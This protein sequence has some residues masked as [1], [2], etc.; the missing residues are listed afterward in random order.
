MTLNDTLRDNSLSMHNC[1]WNITTYI[2]TKPDISIN[3]YYNSANIFGVQV[4]DTKFKDTKAINVFEYTNYT[5]RCTYIEQIIDIINTIG[6]YI[7]LTISVDNSVF[8]KE[9]IIKTWNK[10]KSLHINIVN[11]TLLPYYKKLSELMMFYDFI[12]DTSTLN[13][14]INNYTWIKEMEES[15][16]TICT[17][18]PP[19]EIDDIRDCLKPLNPYG[20]TIEMDLTEIDNVYPHANTED[21]IA[22]NIRNQKHITLELFVNINTGMVTMTMGKY[23]PIIWDI[24]TMDITDNYKKILTVSDHYSDISQTLEDSLN[25]S[26][27]NSRYTTTIYRLKDLLDVIRDI[28]YKDEN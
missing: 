12:F 20:I 28:T 7:N 9:S 27:D 21:E 6:K 25:K 14:A 15:K 11:D 1:I 5:N 3:I 22:A 8:N 18:N 17:Y 4:I 23:T 24:P 26:K 16:N 13:D 10:T 2:L 19:M